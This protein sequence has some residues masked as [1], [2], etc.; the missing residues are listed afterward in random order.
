MRER[1]KE[2]YNNYILSRGRARGIGEEGERD[3]DRGGE[4]RGI[5]DG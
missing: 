5:S 4:G 1:L 2:N 3:R